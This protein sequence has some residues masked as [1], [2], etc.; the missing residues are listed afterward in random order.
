MNLELFLG[1]VVTALD[2]ALVA[3][4]AYGA[5]LAF[6][7]ADHENAIEGPPRHGAHPRERI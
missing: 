4:V 2:I 7:G 3:F 1:Y 5:Y 6:R